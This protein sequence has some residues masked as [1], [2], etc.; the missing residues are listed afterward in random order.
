MNDTK[1]RLKKRMDLIEFL[2]YMRDDDNTKIIDVFISFI[3]DQEMQV[4]AMGEVMDKL[5]EVIAMMTGK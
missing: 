2:E 5:N 3:M 1:D 4:M